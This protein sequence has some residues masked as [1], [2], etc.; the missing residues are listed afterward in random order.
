MSKDLVQQHRFSNGLTLIAEPMPGVRSA[1]FSF[2]VPAGSVYEPA[3][4]GGGATMLAEWIMRGAGDLD[5][6]E[7]IGALDD[8]GVTHAENASATAT[9]AHA[10][11]EVASL[12]PFPPCRRLLPRSRVK[13]CYP[14]TPRRP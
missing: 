8:L 3:E 5:S 9:N 6:H 1:A 4:L 13:A 2:L 10:A 12:I 7:L 11:I 14:A